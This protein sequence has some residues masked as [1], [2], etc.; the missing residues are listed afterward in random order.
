MLCLAHGGALE[1]VLEPI[2]HCQAI[3]YHR[4]ANLVG[5]PSE[6]IDRHEM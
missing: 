1:F 3:A 2:E 5:E 4:I 6:S